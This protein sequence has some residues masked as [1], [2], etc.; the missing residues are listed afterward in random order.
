VVHEAQIAGHTYLFLANFAGLQPGQN[1]TP[2][3]RSGIHVKAQAALGKK[4]HWLP[5]METEITVEGQA[6]SDGIT[7]T[8]PA[9]QRGGVAWFE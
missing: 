2:E 5:F 6:S 1:E 8:L 9:L 3:A 4:L 7:F